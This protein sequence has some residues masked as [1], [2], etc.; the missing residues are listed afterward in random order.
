MLDFERFNPF[1]ATENGVPSV[2]V[3][4]PASSMIIEGRAQNSEK[5]KMDVVNSIVLGIGWS[6]C[7]F[8][9]GG[10]FKYFFFSPLLGEDSHFD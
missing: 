10:G 1:K 6:S 5:K 3:F 4:T 7:W 9:L 2:E 8:I